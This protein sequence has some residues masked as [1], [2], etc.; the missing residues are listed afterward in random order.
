MNII[1]QYHLF[2]QLSPEFSVMNLLSLSSNGSH[3]NALCPLVLPSNP[4]NLVITVCCQSPTNLT[5]LRYLS[6]V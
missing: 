2:L 1:R 3:M 6:A 4:F 5:C